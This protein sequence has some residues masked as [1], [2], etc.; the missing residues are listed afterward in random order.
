[1]LPK[2]SR[3]L[4]SNIVAY[5]AL[6]VALGGTSFAA[7]TLKRGQVKNKHIAANAVT[8]PKV[9]NATLR[10]E[11]FGPGQLP[12]GDKGDKGDQGDEGDKGD[13]GEP[14][15]AL[16]AMVNSNGTLK[17]GEGVVSV[18]NRSGTSTPNGQY[19]VTFGSS[20]ENCSYLATLT[21]ADNST[22]TGA[23]NPLSGEAS[24]A[25]LGASSLWVETRNSAGTLTAGDFNVGVFC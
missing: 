13:V 7:V 3:H 14:A 23:G 16:W 10:S 21:R 25:L 22:S 6:F 24:V 5:L 18:A 19:H 8:A 12:Q 1:M 9:K 20:V 17:R 2:L 15:T 4:R 11:D